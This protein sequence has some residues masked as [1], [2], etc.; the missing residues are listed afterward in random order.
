MKNPRIVLLKFGV[1]RKH[2]PFTLALAFFCCQPRS[3]GAEQLTLTT[4]YP[5]PYG[6][7]VSI[8][9]TGK[10]YLARDTDYVTVGK[11]GDTVDKLLV[12]GNTKID[13]L[14]VKNAASQFVKFPRP[15]AGKTLE[16]LSVPLGTEV[17][18]YSAGSPYTGAAHSDTCDGNTSGG[19]TCAN[20][21]TL[22][23]TDVQLVT[24]GSGAYCDWGGWGNAAGGHS[25]SCNSNEHPYETCNKTCI[26]LDCTDWVAGVCVNRSYRYIT[27]HPAVTTTHRDVAVEC[28]TIQTVSVLVAK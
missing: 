3:A 11:T 22:T 20:L 15:P 21:A 12:S 16:W 2:F 9:T 19:F 4:Y 10:T 14:Y 24:Q 13:D 7:Y 1:I 25:D 27:Y 23:C 18:S 8:L 17:D 6:G 28:Q 26:D 5:A